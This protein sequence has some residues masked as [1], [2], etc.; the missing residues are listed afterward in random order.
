M[1]PPIRHQNINDASLNT[2]EPKSSH[3]FWALYTVSPSNSFYLNLPP[4]DLSNL[5]NRLNLPS[6]DYKRT[7]KESVDEFLWHGVCR[8]MGIK[9]SSRK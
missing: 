7:D 5:F 1:I 9:D 2:T 8:Y 4:F 6:L 3:M